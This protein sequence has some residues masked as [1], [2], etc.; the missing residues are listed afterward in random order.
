MT[1]INACKLLP[2]NYNTQ[3]Y[4][5]LAKLYRLNSK[6]MYVEA[7]QIENTIVKK[8]QYQLKVNQSV[9]NIEKLKRLLQ[10]IL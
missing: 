4:H 6:I 10:K 5:H 3:M 1:Q 2:F 9:R 7:T 8:N